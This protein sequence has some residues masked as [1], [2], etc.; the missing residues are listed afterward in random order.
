MHRLVWFAVLVCV[1]ACRNG[2]GLARVEVRGNVQYQGSPVKHGMI[3]FRPTHG[4]KGPSAG[5]GIVDGK[6]FLPADKGPIAGPHEVEVKIV[7]VAKDST[8]SD[9]SSLMTRGVG[10]LKS[11]SQQVEV[12]RGVEFEFSFP[13]SPP[14]VEK[15]GQ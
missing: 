2:D 9:E 13:P 3:T 15:S 8:K 12:K 4:L 14:L 1:T 7:D 10:Q 5:T 6:F 11:F